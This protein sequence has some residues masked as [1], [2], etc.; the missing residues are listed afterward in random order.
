M[1][2]INWV[3]DLVEDPNICKTVEW[4]QSKCLGFNSHQKSFVLV[5]GKLY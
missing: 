2:V 4:I 3:E 5:N 1:Y